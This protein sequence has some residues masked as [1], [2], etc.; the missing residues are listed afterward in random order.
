[1]RRIEC[2]SENTDFNGNRSLFD[3]N[4]FV[5]DVGCAEENADI[6]DDTYNRRCNIFGDKV[7]LKRFSCTEESKS[8]IVAFGNENY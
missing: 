6:K 2:S 4:L 1:M 3:V 5:H 7:I 8:Y